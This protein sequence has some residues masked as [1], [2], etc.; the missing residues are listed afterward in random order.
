MLRLLVDSHSHLVA[1]ARALLL[2]VRCCFTIVMPLVQGVT[3]LES[4]QMESQRM[5]VHV[6]EDSESGDTIATLKL[7][8]NTLIKHVKEQI[9]ANT[10][11]PFAMQCLLHRLHNGRVEKLW[12]LHG[13]GKVSSY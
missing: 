4:Q 8:P 11:I 9:E 12:Q 2:I 6:N 7:N 1:P 10:S 3:K 13:S 5:T